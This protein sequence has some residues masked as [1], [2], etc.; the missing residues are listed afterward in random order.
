MRFGFRR[1]PPPTSHRAG[2]SATCFSAA[3]V[4]LDREGAE[5]RRAIRV[6]QAFDAGRGGVEMIAVE[7]FGRR[8]IEI[9]IAHQSGERSGSTRP[10][11]PSAP[12]S[13]KASRAYDEKVV[14]QR[15]GGPV[16][17][18]MISPSRRDR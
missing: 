2:A 4:D 8:A 5:R 15:I 6:A 9:G 7:R 1:P 10:L 13:S 16:S 17:K 18:A 14:D 11:A 12:F 3:A